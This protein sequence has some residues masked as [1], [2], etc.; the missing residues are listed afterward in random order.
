MISNKD[1]IYKGIV[2]HK[3]FTPIVHSFKYNIFMAYFDISNIENKFKKSI[4]WNVNK[5]AL[6]SF[7]RKD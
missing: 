2:K 1:Y 3:R 5:F 7:Y 6:A 4:G